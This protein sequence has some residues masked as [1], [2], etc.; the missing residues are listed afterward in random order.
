MKISMLIP[1]YYKEIPEY[2]DSS[3]KSV[4]EQTMRPAEIVLVEDGPLTTSLYLIIKK[5]LRNKK[6]PLKRVRLK[7]SLGLGL[8]LKTGLDNCRF[9]WVARMDSDDICCPRR[10][11]QQTKFICE[12]PDTSVV[13]GYI[14]EFNKDPKQV[15]RIRKVP[16]DAKE[17]RLFSKTRN[18]MNHVAVLFKKKDVLKAGSYRH[19]PY[20]E[21]YDLWTR[22]LAFGME[23]RNI[24]EILVLARF[25]QSSLKRRRGVNYAR[26]ERNLFKNMRTLGLID[27]FT[28]WIVTF[29]RSLIRLGP[30]FILKWTY[31]YFV[32]SKNVPN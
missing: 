31:Q 21:D 26:Y 30:D 23:L 8:A 27:N 16:L 25:D 6:I 2:F 28:F 10:L 19:F 14:A 32:R 1:V 29:S 15:E 5:Y 24:P 11:E 12:N 17:I 20:F 13:S 3:L 7:H 9:D 18:P 22:M 4:M